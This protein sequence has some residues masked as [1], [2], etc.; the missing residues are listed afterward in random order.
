MTAPMLAV[1]AA[2]LA[3]VGGSESGIS[4]GV[5]T[6]LLL[7]LDGGC[8]P[9]PSVYVGRWT[10]GNPLFRSRATINNESLRRSAKKG[11]LRNCSRPPGHLAIR[12]DLDKVRRI[13]MIRG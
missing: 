2:R 3:D 9:A 13:T 12:A 8:V 11:A 10:R 1:E 4:L 7:R 6:L 5:D